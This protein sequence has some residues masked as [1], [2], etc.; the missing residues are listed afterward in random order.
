ML[1][2]KKHSSIQPIAPTSSGNGLSDRNASTSET[3]PEEPNSRTTP[4]NGR[5]TEKEPVS[6]TL[7]IRLPASPKGVA[8]K[9]SWLEERDRLL[10]QA[11]SLPGVDSMESFERGGEILS[12]IG[13]AIDAVEAMR[14]RISKPFLM[15]AKAIKTA[16]D[17]ACAPLVEAKASLRTRLARFACEER[18]RAIAYA[19]RAASKRPKCET[20]SFSPFKTRLAPYP[21]SASVSVVSKLVYEIRDEG[22]LPR[23]LLSPDKSKIRAWLD[24]NRERLRASLAKSPASGDSLT[25]GLRL[26]LS[27][28]VIR[29]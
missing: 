26:R 25:P 17:A 15:A 10:A 19:R 11:S 18:R 3:C 12:A 20:R 27:T 16:S 22:L 13:S 24:A 6:S 1:S 2:T 4:S 29:R 8:I 28:D 23:E 9:R 7:A 5:K 21:K 14:I